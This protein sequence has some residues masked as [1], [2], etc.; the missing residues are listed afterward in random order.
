VGGEEVF[1]INGFH[2]KQLKHF[3]E[4][5]RSIVVMTLSGDLSWSDARNN[6]VGSTMPAKANKGSLRNDFLEKKSH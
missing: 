6:F 1:L 5:S 4:P 3:I 2:P